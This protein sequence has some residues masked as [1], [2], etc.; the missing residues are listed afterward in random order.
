MTIEDNNNEK[1]KFYRLGKKVIKAILKKTPL[2]IFI[3]QIFNILNLI[4]TFKEKSIIFYLI[5]RNQDFDLKSPK[6]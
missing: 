6:D 4:H 1:K 2:P 5:Y 3:F